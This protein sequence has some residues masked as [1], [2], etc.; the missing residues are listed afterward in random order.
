MHVV[1]VERVEEQPR[2]RGLLADASARD[3]PHVSAASRRRH[4]RQSD[5]H[6][7]R[8]RVHC[9]AVREC[10]PLAARAR[11]LHGLV[12]HQTS[13]LA[14]SSSQ[15]GV[16]CQLFRLALRAGLVGVLEG[17][18]ADEHQTKLAGLQFISDRYAE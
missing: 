14:H 17:H 6:A 4:S 9:T 7:L 16:A 12:R 2:E 5:V 15:P 10:R 3:E 11:T 1:P 13:R 8:S 18:V